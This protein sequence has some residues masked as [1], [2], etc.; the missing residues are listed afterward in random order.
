MSVRRK[1]FRLSFGGA[2]ERATSPVVPLAMRVWF[3]AIHR[4]DETGWAP[5]APGELAKVVSNRIDMQ[6]GEVL[7]DRNVTNRLIGKMVDDGWLREGSSLR[8]LGIPESLGAFGRESD[9]VRMAKPGRARAIARA[10]VSGEAR[11]DAPPTMSLEEADAVLDRIHQLR[12]QNAGAR[13]MAD[14]IAGWERATERYRVP[15]Y[16]LADAA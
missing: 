16:R 8:S 10:K 9:R 1:F 5:F 3:A 15:G 11:D 13:V 12:T 6:T 7:T 2:Y 14:A 4:V